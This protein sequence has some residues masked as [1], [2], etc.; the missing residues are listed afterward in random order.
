MR[1]RSVLV[2]AVLGAALAA[3]SSCDVLDPKGEVVT[4]TQQQLCGEDVATD[5]VTDTFC[6]DPTDADRASQI[7]QYEKDYADTCAGARLTCTGGA[8]DNQP[9]DCTAKCV[10]G[11]ACDFNPVPQAVT[12]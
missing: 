3:A 4:C 7:K 9:A 11:G 10:T 8:L 1:T 2:L 5:P 12:L 6:T